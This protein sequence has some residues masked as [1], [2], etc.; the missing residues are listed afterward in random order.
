MASNVL[1]AKRANHFNTM[2][3]KKVD[4]ARQINE[5]F[6]SKISTNYDKEEIIYSV[7]HISSDKIIVIIKTNHKEFQAQ[8]D[9]STTCNVIRQKTI[10]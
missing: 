8:F 2:C 6:D 10:K 4:I 1:T 7:N 3:R 5:D 9:S